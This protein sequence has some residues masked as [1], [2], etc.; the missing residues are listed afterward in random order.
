MPQESGNGEGE[1]V[2][3]LCFLGSCLDFPSVLFCPTLFGVALSFAST[4]KTQIIVAVWFISTREGA[5]VVEDDD[6]CVQHARSSHLSVLLT[7]HKTEDGYTDPLGWQ[8]HL[9]FG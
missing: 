8:S 6:Q 7:S 4:S 2:G 3:E 1:G 9:D 5:H